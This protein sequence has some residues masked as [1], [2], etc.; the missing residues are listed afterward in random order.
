MHRKVSSVLAVVVIL[1]MLIAAAPS[2]RPRSHSPA[3]VLAITWKPPIKS[4]CK[5]PARGPV[6]G[7][8]VN[9][10]V[11]LLQGT[12]DLGNDGIFRAYGAMDATGQDAAQVWVAM[13]SLQVWE[14]ESQTD[15]TP[16]VLTS[17]GLH[18]DYD[19]V[20]WYT[21]HRYAQ[22]CFHWYEAVMKYYIIWQ[23][24][25]RTPTGSGS[26]TWYSGRISVPLCG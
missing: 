24:G 19:Y 22:Y 15:P 25:Q 18:Q 7:E 1:P 16:E 3:N 5:N 2:S 13:T 14:F 17:S 12:D 21:P 6:A 8:Y 10:C 4:N 9:L 11:R 20:N 26:D 23:N